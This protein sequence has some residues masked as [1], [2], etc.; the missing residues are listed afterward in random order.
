[1][2]ISDELRQW[3]IEERDQKEDLIFYEKDPGRC[4]VADTCWY[5]DHCK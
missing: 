3:F 4:Q 2:V 5:R 1:L